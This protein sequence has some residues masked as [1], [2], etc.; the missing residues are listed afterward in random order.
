MKGLVDVELTRTQCWI[1]ADVTSKVGALW[2]QLSDLAPAG[3]DRRLRGS[4]VCLRLLSAGYDDFLPVALARRAVR[5]GPRTVT[6]RLDKAQALMLGEVLLG[7]IDSDIEAF[8]SQHGP[9]ITLAAVHA[10][11]RLITKGRARRGKR[12]TVDLRRARALLRSKKPV[13]V[14][15]ELLGVTESTL[16]RALAKHPATFSE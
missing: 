13:R 1:V 10:A 3:S 11:I 16:R 9:R 15:A 12:S 5:P 8:L 4:A 2:M 7:F 6:I 14:A